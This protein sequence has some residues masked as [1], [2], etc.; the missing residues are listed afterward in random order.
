MIDLKL[1]RDKIDERGVRINHV[2]KMAGLTKQ[3][4][5][6]RLK[7][8]GPG[9]RVSELDGIRAALHLND[10]EFFSLFTQ[11]DEGAKHG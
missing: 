9:F 4:F 10:A 5:H 2:A 8:I 3:G 7:G 1:L 11:G 6:L